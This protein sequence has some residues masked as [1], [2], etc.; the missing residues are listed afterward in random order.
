MSVQMW[1]R[2][3]VERLLQE[4]WQTCK[5]VQD[6]DGDY[7]WRGR[8]AHC[9]V[10]IQKSDNEPLVIVNAHAATKVKKSYKLLNE[11]NEIQCKTPA[12]IHWCRGVVWVTATTSS[13]GLTRS[14]L[15]DLM[16][17]VE[18]IADDIGPMI[19]AVYGGSTPHEPRGD[20]SAA[21]DVA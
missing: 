14:V 10:G 5:L 16:R 21:E 13:V 17:H 2:S 20:E 9:W 12:V 19:A 18:G 11:L 7:P 4:E 1:A 6:P 3:H 15:S 8:T